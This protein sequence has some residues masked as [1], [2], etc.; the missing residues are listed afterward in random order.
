MAIS[1]LHELS[2][3]RPGGHQRKG[4]V[5]DLAHE[6]DNKTP[7]DEDSSDLR[8]FKGLIRKAEARGSCQVLGLA[9]PQ[10]HF[11]DL[12][13]YEE[14]RYRQFTTGEKDVAVIRELCQRILPHQIYLTGAGA[15]PAA[16]LGFH[17]ALSPPLSG[18]AAMNPG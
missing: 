16:L 17:F 6:L 14:G 2:G 4:R 9:L 11:L 10:V 15:E 13:F 5:E 7:F 3:T 12:P 1:L 8:Q 18:C